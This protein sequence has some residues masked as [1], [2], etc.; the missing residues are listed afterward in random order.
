[1]TKASI[2]V[3]QLS[4][5]AALFFILGLTF[6]PTFGT[7]LKTIWFCLISSF[8]FVLIHPGVRLPFLNFW[9]LNG[10]TSG[11]VNLY[12]CKASFITVMFLGA[13]GSWAYSLEVF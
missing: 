7:L 3:R 10:K 5:P 8:R 11:F 2:T 4:S 12:L 9:V 6:C 1:M 13:S